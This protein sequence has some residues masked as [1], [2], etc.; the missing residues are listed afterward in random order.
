MRVWSIIRLS[1]P[2]VLDNV[3]KEVLGNNVGASI[4]ISAHNIADTR[5]H[6]KADTRAHSKADAR[7]HSIANT[8]AHS[9]ADRELKR[10][11]KSQILEATVTMINIKANSDTKEL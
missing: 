5:A 2:S 10:N 3:N 8:R 4:C 6:S 7:A 1:G 11:I 9:K